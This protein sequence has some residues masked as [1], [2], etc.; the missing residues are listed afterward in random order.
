MPALQDS[1]R[2]FARHLRDPGVAPEPRGVSER[3]LQIYRE[4]VYRNIEGFIAGG[5]P[6]LQRLL[7]P[8]QWD[9]LV[10]GFI[11][12]HRCHTP[13]FLRIAEE[14]LAFLQERNTSGWEPPYLFELAHYEWVELALDVADQ[15]LPPTSARAPDLD[16]VPRLS[17]LARLLAYNYPVQQIGPANPFPPARAT[18][19]L[20]FRD[21][22]DVVRFMELNAATSR[23]LEYTQGNTSHSVHA[24]LA[25]L[26]PEIGVDPTSIGEF[27]LQQL[28]DLHAAGAVILPT[29]K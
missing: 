25:R 6:V 3:R 18:Y 22:A 8:E 9:E 15:D 20:V 7:S 21:G 4:L 26:G 13:Y 2:A 1:Q 23:L 27:A 11:R 5:F 10:R 12:D 24:I 16:S 29:D 19:L 17:P 28:S 14:F